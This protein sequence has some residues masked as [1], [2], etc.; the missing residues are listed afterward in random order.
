MRFGAMRLFSKDPGAAPGGRMVGIA[1]SAGGLQA[2]AAVL[3]CLPAE[4]PAPVLVVK[5]RTQDHPDFLAQILAQRTRMEVRE[6]RDRDPLHPGVVYLCPAGR[7]AG[8]AGGVVRVDDGPAVNFTR[9]SADLLFESL[10]VSD[11]ACAVGV[12]LTGR[13]R[14]GAAGAAAIRRRGGIVLAQDPATCV[15]PGMPEALLSHC[16]ADFVLPPEKIGHALVCLVQAP[17]VSA[18]LFG[19]AAPLLAASPG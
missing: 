18:A 8:V 15:A 14:D 16:G 5:H 13:G 19:V 9:P 3:S 7:Q 12:V 10:A 6:A 17:S 2:L 11:G 1:A 4:F